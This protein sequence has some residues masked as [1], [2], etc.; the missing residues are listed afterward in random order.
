MMTNQAM[1]VEMTREQ[2]LLVLLN[3]VSFTSEE[4]ETVRSLL[5]ENLYWPEIFRIAIKNKI[6]GLL[7]ANLEKLRL[8]YLIPSRY[9]RTALFFKL[10]VAERN[11]GY[12]EESTRIL[13]KVSEEGIVC[14]L[15]KGSYLIPAIYGLGPRDMNDIDILI[16]R[17]DGKKVM[18]IMEAFG[19]VQG[20]FS[21]EK[22]DIEA[23][24]KEKKL[25]WKMKMNNLSP[26]VKK[27]ESPFFD[28]Y[29]VDF[30]FNL[31]L[32][33]KVDPV[34][35]MLARAWQEDGLSY[36]KPE[37]FFLHLCCHLYKE[38]TNAEWIYINSDINF[39]KFC[40]VR[41]YVLHKMDKASLKEAVEFAKQYGLEKSIYF[42]V[43]Y[44]REIYNDGYE[45]ELLESIDIPADFLNYYG[46]RNF[47]NPLVWKKDFWG[48]LFSDSN[49]DELNSAEFHKQFQSYLDL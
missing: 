19:Y 21:S 4:I 45:T 5:E 37:D 10:G 40:D 31:D 36:L 47:A 44:L 6:L 48:R 28:H 15:L 25:L 8:A 11:K 3:R 24:T 38:A 33:L 1:Q 34:K 27:S 14:T 16:N 22:N 7:Y 30:S 49:K 35:E 13:Q 43:Y 42:T 20:R 9:R 39:I 12:I 18:Q 26:F 29:K 23:Y 46:D 32:E 17:E 41:E 2:R